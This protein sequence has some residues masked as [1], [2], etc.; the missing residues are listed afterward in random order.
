MLSHG[1]STR[2]TTATTHP[3]R[4]RRSPPNISCRVLSEWGVSLNDRL[5]ELPVPSFSGIRMKFPCLTFKLGPL[6]TSRSTPVHVFRAPTAALGAVGIKTEEDL[7]RFG[8]LYLVHPWIDFLL[9]RQAVG[10]IAETIPEDINDQSS[11]MISGSPSF[12]GPPDLASAAPQTRAARLV[13]RLGRPFTF[14]RGTAS[15]HQCRS[16]TNRCGHSNLSLD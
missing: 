11:S 7:S 14:P 9:D 16:R 1:H 3:R 10:S 13:A 4:Q 5:H 8:S 15:L 2:A 6:S 12:A